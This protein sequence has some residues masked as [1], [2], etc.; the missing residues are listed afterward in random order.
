M[1]DAFHFVHQILDHA[2]LVAHLGAAQDRHERLFRMLQGLAQVFEFLFHEQ[3]G[4]GFLHEFRDAH[5]GSVGAVR[6]PE[7]VIHVVIR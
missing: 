2:D 1:I 7:G 4:C 3:A 5:G 6:G